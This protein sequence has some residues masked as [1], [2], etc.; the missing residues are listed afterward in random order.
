MSNNVIHIGL[1][2]DDT[3]YHDS[4]VDKRSGEVIHFKCRP[5]LKGMST[6]EIADTFK[7][8]YDAEV[9]ATLISQVTESV[10]EQ[11]LLWQ[12]SLSR[13]T[14]SGHYHARE[15]RTGAPSLAFS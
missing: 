15:R 8:M 5:A 14:K 4:T 3:R 9:S 10:L 11:V 13:G 1:D 2:V 7:E 12:Q 6:R